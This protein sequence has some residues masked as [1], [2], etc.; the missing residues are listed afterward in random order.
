MNGTRY[1]RHDVIF[2]LYQKQLTI[3]KVEPAD[4]DPSDPK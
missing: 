2:E 3:L 4:R 1:M